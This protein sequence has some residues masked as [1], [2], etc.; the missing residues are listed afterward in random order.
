[1]T[2]DARKIIANHTPFHKSSSWQP[3]VPDNHVEEP[4]LKNLVASAVVVYGFD[5]A[6]CDRFVIRATSVVSPAM[7]RMHLE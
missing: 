4:L 2:N 1:M 5:N 7:P 3:P 6:T